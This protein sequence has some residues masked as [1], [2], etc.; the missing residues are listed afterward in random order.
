[1]YACMCVCM[2]VCVCMCMY[3]MYVSS[4]IHP[5]L[6]KFGFG[7]ETCARHTAEGAMTSRLARMINRAKQ[8]Y[9]ANHA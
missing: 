4:I 5:Q 1:M 9:C 2:C 3:G 8:E 7:Y 6:R